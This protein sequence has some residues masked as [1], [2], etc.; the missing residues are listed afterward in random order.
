MYGALSRDGHVIRTQQTADVITGR[1]VLT[2]V[3]HL[4]LTSLA[5]FKGTAQRHIAH[6]HCCTAISHSR[7]SSSPQ[8]ETLSP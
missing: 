5:V 1:S 6:P 4:T 3:K 2:V 7:A 8:T